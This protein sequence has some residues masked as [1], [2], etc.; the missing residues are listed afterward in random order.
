MFACSFLVER[1][2]LAIGL[3][4]L[5]VMFAVSYLSCHIMSEY[6]RQP[7]RGPIGPSFA[8]ARAL[9]RAP[10][11]HCRCLRARVVEHGVSSTHQ[12]FRRA[13]V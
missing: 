2:D 11:A 8:R 4:C 1:N 5:C 6:V 10:A 7:A 9:S 13:R 3:V 12:V